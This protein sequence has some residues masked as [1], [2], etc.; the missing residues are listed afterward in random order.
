MSRWV[1]CMTDFFKL[2][3]VRRAHFL[4]VIDALFVFSATVIDCHEP[5]PIP[6]ADVTEQ[7][8]PGGI[9]TI[10]S[11]CLSGCRAYMYMYRSQKKKRNSKRGR[12]MHKVAL[13]F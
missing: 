2:L 8:T 1:E 5:E 3:C 4:H 7:L 12:P 10:V 6:T 11:T 13:L 9:H